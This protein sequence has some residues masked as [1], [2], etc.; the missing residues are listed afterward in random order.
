MRG[1]RPGQRPGGAGDRQG[2][3]RGVARRN[4]RRPG[5]GARSGRS[6]GPAGFYPSVLPSLPPCLSPRPRGAAAAR[7]PPVSAGPQ[8]LARW[9]SPERPSPA[10]GA[11]A[12]PGPA[13]TAAASPPLAGQKLLTPSPRCSFEQSGS[14][15]SVPRRRLRRMSRAGS[16]P[17]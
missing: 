11:A 17:K 5:L 8:N 14:V 15:P 9:L 13:P 2:G 4:R 6:A 16:T 10:P 12:A 3:L 1:G 7:S